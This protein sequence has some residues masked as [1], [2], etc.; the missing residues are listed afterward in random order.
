MQMHIHAL[1]HKLK[2]PAQ[3]NTA[4]LLKKNT[5]EPRRYC[6]VFDYLFNVRVCSLC[7]AC[8]YIYKSRIRTNINRRQ[9]Y[10]VSEYNEAHIVDQ[11]SVLVFAVHFVHVH[12]NVTNHFHQV[13][14]L[15]PLFHNHLKHQFVCFG[16][17]HQ[18]RNFRLR[19]RS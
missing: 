7:L 4:N 5:P 19:M 15:L 1:N 14:V 2:N 13:F 3:R 9:I 8:V 12:E 18:L 10:R 6:S 17:R 16:I 11:R